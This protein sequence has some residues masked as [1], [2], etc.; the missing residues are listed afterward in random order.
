MANGCRGLRKK[1][2]IWLTIEKTKDRGWTSKF[3]EIEAALS[4]GLFGVEASKGFSNEAHSNKQDWFGREKS[5]R[6]LVQ[7][8]LCLEEIF[9]GLVLL[10]ANSR[11]F[12]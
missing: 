4:L 3:G 10:P 9:C 8:Q 7:I 6:L 5:V 11:K 12:G 1:K 2:K